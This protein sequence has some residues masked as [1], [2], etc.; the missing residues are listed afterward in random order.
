V[1]TDTLAKLFEH[2]NWANHEVIAACSALTDEQLDATP[3]RETDWT[4]RHALAHLVESQRGYLSLLTL[5]PE[6]RPRGSLPFAELPE[7]AQRSGEGLLALARGESTHDVETRIRTRDGYLVEPWVVMLQ[8]I[9]HATDHRRQICSMM[10]AQG[11]AAPDLDGWTFGEAR[12]A[13]VPPAA[14]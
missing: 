14:T 5:P 8:V 11:I 1:N 6:A 12:G 3:L 7:S 10:R 9:N 4:I 2:N 13:L